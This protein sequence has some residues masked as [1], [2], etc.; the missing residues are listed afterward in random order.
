MVR[1][2]EY[3]IPLGN[4]IN[5][6]EEIAKTEAEIEYL[7]GF[8]ASVMKKL[9][10]EKFVANAKPE[11]VANERKKQADAESKL[12]TLRATLAQLRK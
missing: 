12:A 5:V 2:T 8:L 9:G 10:N 1:T 6:E 7:T 11:I 4:N 3:A